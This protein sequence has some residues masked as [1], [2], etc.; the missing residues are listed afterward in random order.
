MPD[1]ADK[2]FETLVAT[3]Y[4]PL[5]KF[6]WSLSKKQEDASDLTQQTFLIWAEKGHTLRDPAKVKSWLFTSLYR[7]F[8]RQN[9]RG[10][11]VTAI[12]QEVLETHHDT[13]L[14]SSVRQ[15]EREEAVQALETLDPVYREP[16]ILFYMEDLTYKEI[17]EVLDIP[18]GTVMSRLARAK[19]QLKKFLSEKSRK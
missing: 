19:G 12:D 4:Q 3:Y 7:E 17:A 11:K 14:V 16:L 9:R 15:M 13:D 18:M 6:A 2:A 5:Y 8:L 10:Q 1:Q